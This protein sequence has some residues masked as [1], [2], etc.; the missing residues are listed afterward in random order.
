MNS[1]EE[2]MARR[3]VKAMHIGHCIFAA[4]LLALWFKCELVC[5]V[6]CTVALFASIA[7]IQDSKRRI[8][9]AKRKLHRFGPPPVPK[10]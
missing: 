3:Y 4:G 6:G 1:K 9:E 7:H 8:K 10:Q 5:A 2:Y